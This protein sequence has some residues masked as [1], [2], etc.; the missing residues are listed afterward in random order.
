M[1][2]RGIVSKFI[3]KE[4]LMQD[5][6]RVDSS[7]LSPGWIGCVLVLL[8]VHQSYALVAT[9]AVQFSYVF[10]V[11]CQSQFFLKSLTYS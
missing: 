6:V 5:R 4:L 1:P 11:F 3:V 9:Q 7:K 2:V 10:L 8:R